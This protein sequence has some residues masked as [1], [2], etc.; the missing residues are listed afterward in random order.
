MLDSKVYGLT[1]GRRLPPSEVRYGVYLFSEKRKPRYV[2]RVGLTERS[3]RAGKK[4]SS[5][6]TRLRGHVRSAREGTYTYG[7]AVKTFRRKGLPLAETR[8][9]N[10]EDAKFMGE[11]SH[12][13]NRVHAMEYRLVQITNNRLAAMFEIYAATVLGLHKQTFAV[14]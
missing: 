7:R 5:F 1:N 10:C 13:G 2:G 11:F 6:R 4:F 12:Q 9:A 8:K 3:K 14:S